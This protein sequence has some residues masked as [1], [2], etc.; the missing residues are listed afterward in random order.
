MF[1]ATMQQIV[2]WQDLCSVIEPQIEPHYPKAG[3]GRPPIGLE[4]M[5]R[6]HLVQHWFNLVDEACE[7]TLMDST[8][9][10]KLIHSEW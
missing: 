9:G 6:M 7:E 5:L 1:L 4:R 3:N 10:R 2:P 8:I